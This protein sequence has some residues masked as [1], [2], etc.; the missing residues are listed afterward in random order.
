MTG[1]WG[2]VWVGLVAVV[3]IICVLFRDSQ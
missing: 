1:I 2:P 3:F